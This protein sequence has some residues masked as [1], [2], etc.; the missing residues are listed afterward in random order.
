MAWGDEHRNPYNP[1]SSGSSSGGGGG[2]FGT[3]ARPTGGSTS[4]DERQPIGVP[5][6]YVVD[7]PRDLTGMSAN[8]AENWA[9]RGAGHGTMAA[10]PPRYYD[11]EE[12]RP[13][14]MS[15]Q[16]IRELQMQM[17]MVGLLDSTFNPGVWGPDDA[18]AFKDL[19]A[20]AN[21][22]GITWEAALANYTMSV[23]ETGGQLQWNPETGTFEPG[24]G[25]SG[26]AGPPALVTRTTDPLVLEHMFRSAAIERAGIGWDHERIQA[27]VRTYNQI[28]T[29]RQRDLY[30]AQLAAAE[31]GQEGS[32][33]DI[34][35][36]D[37][38]FDA[39]VEENDP[40]NVR[41]NDTLGY[42]NDFMALAGSTAWGI[43][44]GM[45]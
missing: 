37:A 7:V 13:A 35:S 26:M 12:W 16:A 39:Y 8:A 23:Q 5:P 25:S 32:V 42:I 11:G 30:N 44:G 17:A 29:Q 43:G 33:V 14:G 24:G 31:L 18:T 41:M 34:P 4:D 3:S 10:R 20:Y 2:G 19:L 28:E 40:E 38:W 22:R 21:A 15:P 27:A 6:G 1:F 45:Q 9:E 36:P